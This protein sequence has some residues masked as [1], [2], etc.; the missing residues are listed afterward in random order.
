[1]RVGLAS[2]AIMRL[3]RFRARHEL[4]TVLILVITCATAARWHGRALSANATL[5]IRGVTLG[6]NKEAVLALLGQPDKTNTW[7]TYQMGVD[8]DDQGFVN[9]VGQLAQYDLAV[10]GHS[11]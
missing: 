8:Y 10:D 11:L 5:S 2:P 1:M 6:M 7:S 4:L 3:M 9:E